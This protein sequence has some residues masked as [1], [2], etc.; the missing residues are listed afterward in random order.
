MTTA[1]ATEVRRPSA[2]RVLTWLL[3]ATAAATVV[4]DALNWW[5]A[6]ERGF[7]LAVRSGWALLR[8]LGFLILIRHVRR[9]RAGARPFGLILAVTTVFAVGR[10]IV[11]RDGV[12]ALPG[13]LGFA[14][15]AVLCVAVVGLLYRSTAL[16]DFLVR[17][18]NRL[19]IDRQ[20]IS[21]REV[22]PRRPPVAG[23]LL[24]ARVAAFTYGPLTLVPCL[25]AIGTIL[26][27]QLLAVPTVVLWFGIGIGVSH[28]VLFCTFFLLRGKAWAGILLVL[29]SVAV[30]AVDLAFCW[31]LLGVDGLVR[32]GVPLLVAAG[33]TLYALRRANSVAPATAAG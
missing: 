28:A 33:L 18:P 11:P 24:T 31:L 5:Y 15:L 17:H 20:G 21:W 4:V 23:W 12:P 13:A 22:A 2:V 27:G 26:D 6:D 32:D 8:T 25:V 29:V 19:V 9:G 3:A 16:R 7:G 10:L 1:A 14:V 30:V